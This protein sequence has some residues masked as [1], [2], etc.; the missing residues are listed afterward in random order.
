MKIRCWGARGSL[1][2]SGREFDKYGGNTTCLEIRTAD[3]RII[4]VDAGTGIQKLGNLLIREDRL[5]CHMVFTHAHWDH[6]MGFPFFKPIYSAKAEIRICG[7]ICAQEK[8]TN[9]VSRTMEKPYFPIDYSQIT[10]NIEFDGACKSRFSIG[11]VEISTIILNHPQNGLGYRFTENGKS[12]VFLTDNELSYRHPG[13]LEFD[14]YVRFSEGADLLIHD[15]EYREDEYGLT[16]SWGHSLYTDAL[17]L[18]MEAGIRTR[19]S[20]P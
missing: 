20:I 5:T 13:G 10:S 19:I 9:L 14:D 3:D 1:P 17:G 8:V 16:R 7:C 2:V 18:A 11:S 15:A 6:L 12:F 4:I